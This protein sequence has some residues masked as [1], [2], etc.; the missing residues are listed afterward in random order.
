LPD[1][2]KDYENR[3]ISELATDIVNELLKSGEPMRVDISTG[4]TAE[5]C[6]PNF[7]HCGTYQCIKSFKCGH[8]NG[9]TCSQ[10]F[11]DSADFR[12]TLG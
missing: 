1:K 7:T 11:S 5:K 4:G 12:M 6:G 9:F 2:G 8:E 3:R 10:K